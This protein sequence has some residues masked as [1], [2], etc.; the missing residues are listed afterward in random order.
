[1]RKKEKYSEDFLNTLPVVEVY[2]LVLKGAEVKKFPRG[3]WNTSDSKNNAVICTKYMIENILNY[4]E[5]DIKRK[6]NINVFKKNKLAGM[7]LCV[8]N[9]SVYSIIDDAYPNKFM[10][11]ELNNVPIGYWSNDENIKNAIIWMINKL[12]WTDEDIKK[13]I[14]INTFRDAKLLGLLQNKYNNSVYRAMDHVFPNKFKPWEFKSTKKNYWSSLDNCR[15]ATRWLLEEK[16]N[17]SDD[18]ILECMST[19]VFKEYGL[20]GMLKFAYNSSFFEAINDAYPNRFKKQD[21]KSYKYN[22]HIYK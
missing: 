10:P 7:M 17:L 12:N 5:E 13:N 15:S 6:L 3:F 18:E 8:Y 20:N 16:L 21:F 2:K 22:I 11:W 19:K 14:S 1:M 9:N 4:S